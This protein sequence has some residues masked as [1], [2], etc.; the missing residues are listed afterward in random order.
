M[1]T[2]AALQTM[3]KGAVSGI[4]MHGMADGGVGGNGMHG[5]A[6]GEVGGVGRNGRGVGG[7]GNRG[8]GGIGSMGWAI[9]RDVTSLA[10]YWC[11]VAQNGRPA[12]TAAE[13]PN[14][15]Q[16]PAPTSALCALCSKPV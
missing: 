9:R 7:M 3:V 5:M 14:G 12:T 10:K 8:V 1:K 4:G 15:V 6:N 13:P 16:P 11:L 2:W